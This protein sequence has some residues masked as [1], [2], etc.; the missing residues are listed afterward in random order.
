M[1]VKILRAGPMMTVQDSG[2]FGYFDKGITQSG[3]LDH[4]SYDLVNCV[5]GNH[6]NEAVIE[7]IICGGDFEFTEN[8]FFALGGADM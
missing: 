4:Y 5:L 3:V 7:M 2:R 1:A 6:R 8:T